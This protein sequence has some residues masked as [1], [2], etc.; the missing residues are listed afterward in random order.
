[1]DSLDRFIRIS[2]LMLVHIIFGLSVIKCLH[3]GTQEW[4]TTNSMGRV[5]YH[6]QL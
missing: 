5:I 1:M 4:I 6:K 2:V 3:I